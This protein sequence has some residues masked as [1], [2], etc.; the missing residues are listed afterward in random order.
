MCIHAYMRP[1]CFTGTIR[2]WAIAR[3]VVIKTL[4][5]YTCMPACMNERMY[6]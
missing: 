5:Q 1:D 2:T 3:V 6:R 4:A